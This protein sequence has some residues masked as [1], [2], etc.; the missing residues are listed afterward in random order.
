[1]SL[2]KAVNVPKK[3]KNSFK[4]SKKIKVAEHLVAKPRTGRHTPIKNS[5]EYPFPRG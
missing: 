3:V 5:Q 4:N 1:M 2:S